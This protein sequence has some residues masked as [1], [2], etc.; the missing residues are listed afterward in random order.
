MQ[1]ADSGAYL[2]IVGTFISLQ[3]KTKNWNIAPLWGAPEVAAEIFRSAGESSASVIWV[4]GGG[5]GACD[6]LLTP[7]PASRV[8]LGASLSSAGDTGGT[9]QFSEAAP[10][11]WI[12]LPP[13]LKS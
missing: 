2:L 5:P 11:T 13:S 12:S 9:E 3:I 10:G 1:L 7:I 8:P 4:L 6:A